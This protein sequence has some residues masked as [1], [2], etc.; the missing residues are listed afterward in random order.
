LTLLPAAKNHVRENRSTNDD[1][2]NNRPTAPWQLVFYLRLLRQ[3][4]TGP[5][6]RQFFYQHQNELCELL[7]RSDQLHLEC[8]ENKLE[9]AALWAH[10]L[11]GSPE[12]I[13]WVAKNE[14]LSGILMDFYV[15]IRPGE[16]YRAYN[17]TSLP[18]FYQILNLCCEHEAYLEKVTTHRNFD[19]ALRFLYMES[20]DYPAVATVLFDIL[21]KSAHHMKYRQRHLQ[22]V[23]SYE[24]SNFS[25]DNLNRFFELMLQGPQDFM[26]FCEKRGLDWL[27]RLLERQ[28]KQATESNNETN[29]VINTMDILLKTI[30]WMLT[31]IPSPS[32]SLSSASPSDAPITPPPSSS[33]SSSAPSTPSSAPSTPT[34][35]SPSQLQQ[36]C[37]DVITNFWQMKSVLLDTATNLH[38][39][40]SL[41]YYDLLLQRLSRIL[42][43][44]CT[45]DK[46]FAEQL[47]ASIQEQFEKDDDSSDYPAGII[48]N[49][50]SEMNKRRLMQNRD[51]PN[52]N[53]NNINIDDM[54]EA[55]AYRSSSA[56][57]NFVISIINFTLNP[58]TSIPPPPTISLSPAVIELA[59]SLL[60][61]ACIQQRQPYAVK[62]HNNLQLA[63]LQYM[64]QQNQ[65]TT[66]TA[67]N[68]T[69]INPSQTTTSF[70]Q[71]IDLL[72][73]IW[74]HPIHGP[75]LRENRYLDS[76]ISLVLIDA[77]FLLDSHPSAFESVSLFYSHSSKMMNPILRE[78]LVRSLGERLAHNLNTCVRQKK[79]TNSWNFE[80]LCLV[81]QVLKSL[82]LVISAD[83]ELKP[84]FTQDHQPL[85][86]MLHETVIVGVNNDNNNNNNNNTLS[87]SSE[88]IAPFPRLQELVQLTNS[89][90][91]PST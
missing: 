36:R 4:V 64:I 81:I 12:N 70:T 89:L 5:Q 28:I 19:W 23:L 63:I 14:R 54:E 53:N 48:F 15:S 45:F 42:E 29:T 83:P 46:N 1:M 16:K 73:Q 11:Q 18:P 44:T 33:P 57:N 82:Q 41:S 39:L 67:N 21:V 80:S 22:A 58:T 86:A 56:Y 87:S 74:D 79:L 62:Q 35:S 61:N 38:N 17:N 71:T 88:N 75:I 85:L 43:V 7:H 91:T 65:S 3:L 49:N 25:Y 31:P 77:S 8:D 26:W 9:I 78:K 13:K 32:P 40:P 84:Q 37:A 50:V 24:K 20:G 60:R 76:I 66:S 27:S 51:H 10:I 34:S 59:I 52:N 68:N 90:L 30:E 47:I 72:R 55:H 69:I 6:E 2:M